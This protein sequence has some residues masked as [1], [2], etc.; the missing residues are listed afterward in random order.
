MEQDRSLEKKKKNQRILRACASDS[1]RVPTSVAT[2]MMPRLHT[3]VW[4]KKDLAILK[5]ANGV[6]SCSGIIIIVMVT[7]QMYACPL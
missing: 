2:Y 6:P 5:Y 3:F 1:G 7:T 4:C